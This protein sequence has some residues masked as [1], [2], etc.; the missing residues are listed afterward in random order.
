MWTRS[1]SLVLFTTHLIALCNN[2]S[3]RHNVLPA[4]PC[5]H[6]ASGQFRSR[7]KFSSDVESFNQ[8][9][10]RCDRRQNDESQQQHRIGGHI[11]EWTTL[12]VIPGKES[13]ETCLFL[14]REMDGNQE[15]V[16]LIVS[17]SPLQPL[18]VKWTNRS[19]TVGKHTD[20]V[21]VE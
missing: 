13:S 11:S 12:N 15:L 21:N 14:V 4:C 18:Q 8:G 10:H 17:P 6:V 9:G 20:H 3:T 5:V 2:R 7:E 1:V 19:T 16:F